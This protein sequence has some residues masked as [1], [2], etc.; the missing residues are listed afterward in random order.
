MIP[1][2]KRD[3]SK[4]RQFLHF[5]INYHQLNYHQV[6]RYGDITSAR[7]NNIKIEGKLFI[8][9]KQNAYCVK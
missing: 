9:Q 4:R 5:L 8:C 1:D 2:T 3:I 7:M 6:R